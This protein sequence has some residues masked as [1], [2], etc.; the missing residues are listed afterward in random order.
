MKRIFGLLGAAFQTTQAG[1]SKCRRPSQL[2]PLAKTATMDQNLQ[3]EPADETDLLT[4][5]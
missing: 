1:E 5:D 2:A 3:V 4:V